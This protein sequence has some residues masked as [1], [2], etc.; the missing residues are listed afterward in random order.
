MLGSVESLINNSTIENFWIYWL[1]SYGL[2]GAL[3]MALSLIY[4]WFCMFQRGDLWLKLS[5]FG[6]AL[7][8]YS[9]NSLSAKTPVLL[10]F[11]ISSITYLATT[12]KLIDEQMLSTNG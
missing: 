8:S 5:V 2:I 11:L 3:P 4:L 1:I 12:Q 10:F 7:A 9:N 6:F